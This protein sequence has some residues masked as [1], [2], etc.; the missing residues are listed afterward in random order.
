MVT[1]TKMALLSGLLL[2]MFAAAGAAE[3]WPDGR[4]QAG[5]ARG[6]RRVPELQREGEGERQARPVVH[7]A[8]RLRAACRK[9]LKKSI[10]FCE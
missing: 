6:E 2:S 4:R 5:D 7:E 10:D 1:K 8:G 9:S 3:V